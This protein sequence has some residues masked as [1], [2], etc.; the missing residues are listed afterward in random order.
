MRQGQFQQ[1]PV[2]EEQDEAHRKAAIYLRP[3]YLL[4]LHP[5]CPD[6]RQGEK[7]HRKKFRPQHGRE[8]P[9]G[10]LEVPQNL[11]YHLKGYSPSF[12]AGVTEPVHVYSHE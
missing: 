3:S 2:Q 9:G 8:Q 7:H 1:P 11:V 4:V 6:A 5:L 12:Q 10:T